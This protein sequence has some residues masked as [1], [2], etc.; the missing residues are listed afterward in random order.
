MVLRVA[1]A[2]RQRG[3]PAHAPGREAHP[4]GGGRAPARAARHRPRV[5]P[6]QRWD[7]LVVPT[8][9]LPGLTFASITAPAWASRFRRSTRDALS[10]MGYDGEVGLRAT[11][12]STGEI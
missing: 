10:Y 2:G 5:Q 12:V 1:A 9:S 6:G 11:V 3:R 8:D 7:V 4:R